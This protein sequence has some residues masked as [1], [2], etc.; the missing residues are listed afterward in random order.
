MTPKTDATQQLEMSSSSSDVL[1]DAASSVTAS[2]GGSSGKPPVFPG[3]STSQAK[4]RRA[5]EEDGAGLDDVDKLAAENADLRERLDNA[6]AQ[7][8]ALRSPRI[9][10]AAA[11]V[12]DGV[13]SLHLHH[14]HKT[15]KLPVSGVEVRLSEDELAS[16]RQIFA[17]FD[18]DGSGKVTVSDLTTLYAKL[19]EPLDEREAQSMVAEVGSG[20]EYISFEDFVAYWDGSHPSQRV[21]GDE[22][23]RTA[24]LAQERNR[25][26]QHAQARFKFM[27][28]RDKRKG[29]NGRRGLAGWRAG[30][31]Q[32]A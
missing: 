2:S 6:L 18:K 23:P 7:L 9:G 32:A 21:R 28:V 19:G 29:G 22:S 10:P 3:S 17:L 26:R 30:G 27:K 8:A 13:P 12:S 25:K 11:P 24:D 4:R 20:R 5:S 15:S 31:R 16:M 1:G 14:H